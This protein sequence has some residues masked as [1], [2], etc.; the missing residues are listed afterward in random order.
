MGL[1]GFLY[2]TDRM[3]NT[4]RHNRAVRARRRHAAAQDVQRQVQATQ[5]ATARHAQ[6]E[7]RR[8]KGLSR[9]AQ[10]FKDENH[11][12]L[13]KYG[14]VYRFTSDAQARMAA[15]YISTRVHG[16]ITWDTTRAFYIVDPN[17]PKPPKPAPA[18]QPKSISVGVE[19]V[20]GRASGLAASELDAP[21][22][23]DILSGV[24]GLTYEEFRVL[25]GSGVFGPSDTKIYAFKSQAEAAKAA[26][27]LKRVRIVWMSPANLQRR[28]FSA[29]AK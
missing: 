29:V 10:E 20:Y 25:W 26:K 11:L 14:R 1:F 7:L 4:T 27:S 19:R 2:Q 21:S 28:W 15:E 16:S 17:P 23:A 13:L 18:I 6:A 8:A 24:A 3:V 22:R 5:Q 12:G 9:T